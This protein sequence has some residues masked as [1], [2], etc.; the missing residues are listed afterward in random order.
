MALD[1]ARIKHWAFPEIRQSYAAKDS[2][3]YALGL[4]LGEDPVDARQLRYVYEDGLKAFP[5]QA[6]VLAY[7][8]FWMQNPET[9]IDWV[10][11][12]HGEQRLRLHRPLPAAGT[13]RARAHVSHVIDKGAG[14]GALV[15]TERT[16][17]DDAT[18]EALATL[19]QTTFCR[20]DGGFGQGDT[21]PEPLPAVPERA[22]DAVREIAIL[23]QAALLY[24]LNADPNP[25]HADP[26]VAR[27]AGFE[28]PILHGLCT[29]GVAARAL[30]DAF[31]D[32]DGDRLAE[33]N[34]RF[35]RPVFPGETLQVRMWREADGRVRFDARIPARDVTVLSH[36]VAELRP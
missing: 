26:A 23:P 8:G 11:V 16:L 13:V 32:G 22:P 6:V 19:A 21:P 35:S 17:V 24:R 4:G 1:Y 12:V 9:G 18:G 25:L 33:L 2:I 30:L 29:Y 27:A 20:A 36:G 10:K 7:P 15:I 28:R 31:A 3:F 14:K 5:T 34:V